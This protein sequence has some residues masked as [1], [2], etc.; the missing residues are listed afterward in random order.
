MQ[1]TP[2]PSHKHAEIDEQTPVCPAAEQAALY[3]A[4]A[5]D[6]IITRYNYTIFLRSIDVF[7]RLSSRASYCGTGTFRVVYG[8]YL[9]YGIGIAWHGMA[10]HVF[11]DRPYGTYAV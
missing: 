8:R 2:S 1:I 3:A 6:P 10:W 11:A 9:R 5:A 4:G 7:C